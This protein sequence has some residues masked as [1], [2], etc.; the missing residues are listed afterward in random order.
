VAGAL[1]LKLGGYVLETKKVPI[2]QTSETVTIN[3]LMQDA[4]NK[5]ANNPSTASDY[6][7]INPNLRDLL[8][9]HPSRVVKLRNLVNVAELFDNTYLDDLVE[10]IQTQ[11]QKY[12]KPI[13]MEIPKPTL[14]GTPSSEL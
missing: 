3:V 5:L 12:G 7:G 9:T 2:S 4:V 14:T 13:S 8:E 11:C 10:D 1:G 6:I